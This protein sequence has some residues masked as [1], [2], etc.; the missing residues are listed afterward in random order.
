MIITMSRNSTHGTKKDAPE[1]A[2]L[3]VNSGEQVSTSEST[4]SHTRAKL[5]HK[6][7]SAIVQTNEPL[8][9]LLIYTLTCNTMLGENSIQ[10]RLC[11]VRLPSTIVKF[12]AIVINLSNQIAKIGRAHV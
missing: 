11:S 2:G 1:G 5:S 6:E 8:I 7:F 9:L 12:D 4:Q 10:A 3:C